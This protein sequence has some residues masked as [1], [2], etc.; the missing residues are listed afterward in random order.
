[1]L[2]ED[3]IAMAIVQSDLDCLLE[4]VNNPVFQKVIFIKNLVGTDKRSL[5][6][7]QNVNWFAF[8]G[9]DIYDATF[10]IID[11]FL[12]LMGQNLSSNLHGFKDLFQNYLT[13]RKVGNKVDWSRIC[14]LPPDVVSGKLGEGGGKQLVGQGAG[15]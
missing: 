14:P 5:H 15:L 9:W 2:F 6:G 8:V 3:D 7:I 11:W 1:M 10:I 13:E 4:Q 12:S